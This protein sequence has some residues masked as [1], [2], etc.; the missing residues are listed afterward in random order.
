[1]EVIVMEPD[2][3]RIKTAL[4]GGEK[5]PGCELREVRALRSYVNKKGD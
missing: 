4:A 1:M 3:D 2:K 5:I